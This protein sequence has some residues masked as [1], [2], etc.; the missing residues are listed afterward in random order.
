MKRLS[1]KKK[2]N[3]SK[4]PVGIANYKKRGNVGKVL[5]MNNSKRLP[6]MFLILTFLISMP[7]LQDYAIK[8]VFQL[9]RRK[10][11]RMVKGSNSN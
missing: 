2:D 7:R 4:D 3:R 9:N 5:N 1:L 8:K 6:G 10:Y 11:Y